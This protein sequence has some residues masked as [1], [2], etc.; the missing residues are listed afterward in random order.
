MCFRVIEKVFR[1][2]RVLRD[3]ILISAFALAHPQL[4]KLGDLNENQA[5]L[6][7]FLF[8]LY[9]RKRRDKAYG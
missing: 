8:S 1:F 4:L 2:C 5:L 3:F 7:V 9:L 6:F